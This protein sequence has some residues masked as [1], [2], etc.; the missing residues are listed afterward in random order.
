MP[1]RSL[2]ILFSTAVLIL[3]CISQNLAAQCSLH[4][5]S[6]RNPGHQ[7][8]L[9]SH[10]DCQYNPRATK[11][12]RQ[13]TKVSLRVRV[14][15]SMDGWE[16][17]I[18]LRL[19]NN[20]R[21]KSVK[22]GQ[23]MGGDI[24]Q[25]GSIVIRNRIL[26]LDPNESFP[27]SFIV[28]T[29]QLHP[30]LFPATFR[31]THPPP[32]M[33]NGMCTGKNIPVQSTQPKL[34]DKNR[35]YRLTLHF[36]IKYNRVSSCELSFNVPI[37]VTAVQHAEYIGRLDSYR[38]VLGLITGKYMRAVVEYR[39]SRLGTTSTGFANVSC[40][41]C[42]RSNGA[43]KV[44]TPLPDFD[45]D[46]EEFDM[47]GDLTTGFPSLPTIISPVVLSSR[48]SLTPSLP[49]KKTTD[50]VHVQVIEFNGTT[51]V[52][53][54]TEYGGSFSSPTVDNPLTQLSS[55]PSIRD[56]SSSSSAV[57]IGVAVGCLLVLFVVVAMVAVFMSRCWSRPAVTTQCG[58][59]TRGQAQGNGVHN[60]PTTSSN[61]HTNFTNPGFLGP[62]PGPQ[63]SDEFMK[64]GGGPYKPQD[65]KLEVYLPTEYVNFKD[66]HNPSTKRTQLD[67]NEQ[68]QDEPE[69]Q[70]VGHQNEQGGQGIQDEPEAQDGHEDKRD[71]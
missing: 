68:E 41:L 15:S 59:E 61:G 8:H 38:Y 30:Q 12:H 11:Q 20:V 45:T 50:S 46:D 9:V 32:K 5:L 28:R 47:S 42:L 24:I 54:Y 67:L 62:P 48:S 44:S 3:F 40:L 53:A 56:N 52:H 26:R 49:D 18:Q 29:G 35:E 10:V 43:F 19:T 31:L 23:L 69:N 36:H 21:V 70:D 66:R 55:P 7:T 51:R 27:V 37:R 58:L 64:D 25:N 34:I 57:L 17:T 13:D 16:M 1:S 14:F 71:A 2:T 22:G 33:V 39:K 6:S 65:E 60:R 4:V 63:T